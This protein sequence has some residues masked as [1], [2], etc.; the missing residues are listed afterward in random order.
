MPS[1]L[2][3]EWIRF[4]HEF[5]TPILDGFFKF[6]N[7]FDTQEFLFILLPAIW[8]GIGWRAGLRLFYILLLNSLSNR[9][10]KEA[11]L[12]PRPFHLDPSLGI[13]HVGGFGFPSGA[14]QTAILLTG[15]MLY[16]W[17]N[18]WKW[19]VAFSYIFF[20]SLSRLYLGV[21][22]PI[23]I[24]G[25]WI[26]GLFLLIFFISG[27][28]PLEKLLE[29]IAPALLFFMS[30]L[31]PVLLLVWQHSPHA[32]RICATAMGIGVGLMISYYLHLFLE[33]PQNRKECLLRILIGILGTFLCYGLT[34][35]LPFQHSNF[36]IFIQFFWM[37]LWPGVG[38]HILCRQ[39]LPAQN[40]D[41]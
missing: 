28:L 25:G 38:G 6:L 8:F 34:L 36:F 26:A 40:S 9:A 30:L 39:F 5:R 29:R 18:P 41:N 33:A 4:L 12:S 16:F 15:L 37:G 32:I 3:L 19:F 11:F 21:H 17:K 27:C 35:L 10:L 1:L 22:F 14:A 24:L 23:D 20:I 7:F 31:V 13:I 2:D